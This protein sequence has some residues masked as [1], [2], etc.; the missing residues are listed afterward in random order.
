MIDWWGPIIYEYYGSSE[1]NGATSIDSREALERPGSVGKAL[2]GTIHV[3]DEEGNELPPE[4]DGLIYFERDVLPFHYHNDPQKTKAAQHPRH[5]TWTAVGDIGHLDQ[6]GY[7]YLTDRA[8]FMIISGGVN[9]YPQ[10]IENALALHPKVADVA[11]I[12]VPDPDLG[13]SVKA[14]IEPAPGIASTAALAE[15]IIE[16]LRGKVARYMVPKSVDFIDKMP[17]LP[18]GKLY[19]KGLR[20]K[21][22]SADQA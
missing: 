17:R 6:D 16:Y 7:L 15:E 20:D 1:S 3:C 8:S 10:A 14:I 18:T 4:R 12:G 9:V 2:V 19:K 5:P 22:R 11:I 13:E 21:Y